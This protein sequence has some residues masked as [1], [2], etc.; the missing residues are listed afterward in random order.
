[1]MP[2]GGLPPTAIGL[3][4]RLGSATTAAAANIACLGPPTWSSKGKGQLG[5]LQAGRRARATISEWLGPVRWDLALRHGSQFLERAAAHAAVV[6]ARFDR[7]PLA[8]IQTA[9]LPAAPGK[10]GQC[11]DLFPQRVV[12]CNGQHAVA[13]HLGHLPQEV[14]P[15]IGPSLEDVILPL[16]NHLVRQRARD[17]VLAEWSLCEGS[18]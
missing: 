15:M 3:P 4:A 7:A 16:M 13:I 18:R 6:P 11:D 1:M 17:L 5:Q 8:S 14:G 2:R 12:H 9:T 10:A